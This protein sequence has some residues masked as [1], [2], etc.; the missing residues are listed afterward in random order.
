[1]QNVC[2][3]RYKFLSPFI[4]E[5]IFFWISSKFVLATFKELNFLIYPCELEGKMELKS[6]ERKKLFTLFLI[7]GFVCLSIFHFFFLHNFYHGFRIYRCEFILN[8]KIPFIIPLSGNVSILKLVYI[9][10]F[11]TKLSFGSNTLKGIEA[12][13]KFHCLFPAL[14]F[15]N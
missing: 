9:Y 7:D 6:P 10:T 1:M 15:K 11:L 2:S 14:L 3:T 8:F 13:V 4:V 12:G 5:V